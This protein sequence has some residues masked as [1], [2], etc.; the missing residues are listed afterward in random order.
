M[1]LAEARRIF[2]DTPGLSCERFILTPIVDPQ[3]SWQQIKAAVGFSRLTAAI[4]F[5]TAHAL[6]GWQRFL[7][8]PE[9]L[10]Q[11]I[12]VSARRIG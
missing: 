10:I 3:L 2:T 9:F 6:A 7:P 12:A 8:L 4:V 5:A 11:N 1:T